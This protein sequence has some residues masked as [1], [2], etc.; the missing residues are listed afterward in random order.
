MQINQG[1]NSTELIIAQQPRPKSV[2]ILNIS[3]DNLS[4]IE[5]LD[6]LKHGGIVFTPNV[7]HIVK[8][9]KDEV[10]YTIYQNADYRVCDS[11]ILMMASRFLGSPLKEKISG[12]DLFPA[13]YN[14]YKKDQDIKIFVLGGLEGTAR[15]VQEKVN[16]QANREM[17]V[18][19]YCPPFGFEYDIDECDKIIHKINQSGAT[20][21]AMGV[22]SP[23]QEIWICKH[24][25]KLK[26]VK[27]FLAIGA[28]I[29]FEA[30]YKSRAPKWMSNAGLEWLY[31]LIQEPKRLWKR[32][33]IDDSSFLF[34]IVLQKLNLFPK[35]AYRNFKT[36]TNQN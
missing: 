26:N 12:S 22:G 29:D 19:Y 11:Q 7:D 9:Q 17:V 23:K 35:N 5:L 1:M 28:T 33:L 6:K 27:T 36:F 30:E 21:L 34:L 16:Q 18:D 20:V 2:D 31:R 4:L 13:F 25:N 10:F 32:Y 24:R 3:I 8:L 14:Y 15:K